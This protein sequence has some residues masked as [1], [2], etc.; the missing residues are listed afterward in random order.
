MVPAQRKEGQHGGRRRG[1]PEGWSGGRGCAGGR[2][3]GRRAGRRGAG[4][5]PW[6]KDREGVL[7][8]RREKT[9]SGRCRRARCRRRGGRFQAEVG[10]VPCCSAV[11]RVVLQWARQAGVGKE[12]TGSQAGWA[13]SVGSGVRPCRAQGKPHGRRAGRTGHGARGL[14]LAQ[15][16]KQAHAGP[17]RHDRSTGRAWAA[18]LAHRP[19]RHSMNSSQART[20]CAHTGPYRAGRAAR[21]TR[22][23][24]GYQK[25]TA[26]RHQHR[27]KPRSQATDLK[28]H[29]RAEKSTAI[30]F[31]KK[32][33]QLCFSET[34]TDYSTSS[35]RLV[36]KVSPSGGRE[37]RHRAGRSEPLRREHG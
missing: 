1:E 30:F 11:P 4:A 15:R 16:A 17:A 20:V 18:T 2:S 28:A 37:T 33:R 36:R 7:P 32:N 19:I 14:A 26:T 3:R 5:K 6:R 25:K 34:N 31:F 24:I 8:A 29:P 13:M 27:T 35:G 12:E 23:G 22:S 10:Y 9:G 21:L